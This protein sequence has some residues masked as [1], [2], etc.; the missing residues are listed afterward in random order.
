[1]PRPK[2]KSELLQLGRANYEKLLEFINGFSEEK[3][4]SEFPEGTLYRNISDVLMHLHHWHVMMKEWHDIGM[5][6][7]KPDMPAKGYT[8]KMTPEL[9]KWIWEKYRGTSLESAKAELKKSFKE[10]R[11]IIEQYTDEELFTKKKYKWTGTTSM[12]S[13][14]VSATSSHYDWALKF[15]KKV[16]KDKTL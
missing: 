12:G 13:Y 15:L 11:E 5:T 8:W 2:T 16:T 7:A 4:N 10:I 14:L 6:G 3:L 9:N 1:M